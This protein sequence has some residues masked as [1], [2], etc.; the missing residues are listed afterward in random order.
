VRF[1][2]VERSHVFDMFYVRRFHCSYPLAFSITHKAEHKT[3]V[4]SVYG[5]DAKLDF[6]P[7]KY[8]LDMHE[9]FAHVACHSNYVAFSSI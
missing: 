4:A 7:A 5:R 9:C 6:A 8:A 3:F 1:Y 2:T